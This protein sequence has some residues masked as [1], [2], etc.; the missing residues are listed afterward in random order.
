MNTFIALLNNPWTFVVL[1]AIFIVML[2]YAWK[3]T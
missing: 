3:K 1:I 2:I